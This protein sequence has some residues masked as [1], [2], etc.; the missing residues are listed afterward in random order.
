MKA[1]LPRFRGH[2]WVIVTPDGDCHRELIPTEEAA[3][4]ILKMIAQRKPGSFIFRV[5]LMAA[6]RP[7][8]KTNW[9]KPASLSIWRLGRP[10]RAKQLKGVEA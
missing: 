1:Y 3:Q 5:R 10:V 6:T 8:G 9:K 7:P 4:V 2:W